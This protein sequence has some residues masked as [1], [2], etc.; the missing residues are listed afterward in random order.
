MAVGGDDILCVPSTYY[1]MWPMF[2][3]LFG[4]IRIKIAI[5]EIPTIRNGS[6][7]LLLLLC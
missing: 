2:T 4:S 7:L 1:D 3:K 5:Q 6:S